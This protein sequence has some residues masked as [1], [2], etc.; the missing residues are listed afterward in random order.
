MA[1]GMKGWPHLTTVK[2]TSHTVSHMVKQ[3]NWFQMES[4]IHAYPCVLFSGLTRSC[5]HNWVCITCSTITKTNRT[6]ELTQGISICLTH[7]CL[8]YPAC[9]LC[10]LCSGPILISIII[11]NKK[12]LKTNKKKHYYY[13]DWL[14]YNVGDVGP[15][16]INALWDW[17]KKILIRHMD[18]S[19]R[20]WGAGHFLILP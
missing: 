6:L 13:W 5:F 4:L 16:S 11:K 18:G 9:N 20:A 10:T 15:K 3:H 19:L 2:R 17:V 8:T 7:K 1:H 14:G 12:K